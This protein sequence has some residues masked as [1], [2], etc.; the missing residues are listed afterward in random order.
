MSDESYPDELHYHD[1]HLGEAGRLQ[2][3]EIL[4]DRLH[5][6]RRDAVRHYRAVSVGE[7]GERHRDS[8]S[9]R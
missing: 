4:V 7:R 8:T 5:R 6:M 3:R 1:A 2:Q 9:S